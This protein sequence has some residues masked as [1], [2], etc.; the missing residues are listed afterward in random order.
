MEKCPKCKHEYPKYPLYETFH[1]GKHDRVIYD[2]KSKKIIKNWIMPDTKAVIFVLL[3]FVTLY[4][5]YDVF[6]QCKDAFY[7][8]CK[9]CWDSGCYTPDPK[10]IAMLM[11]PTGDPKDVNFYRNFIPYDWNLKPFFLWAIIITGII[12][13]I[14]LGFLWHKNKD[15][16]KIEIED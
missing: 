2:H 8:P 5:V 1:V 16:F 15:K 11:T 9:F 10:D 12:L 6:G 3:I 13:I 4:G 14:N 7:R